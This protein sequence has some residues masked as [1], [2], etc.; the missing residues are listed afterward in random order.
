MV[1]ASLLC[2]L[3]VQ[4]LWCTCRSFIYLPLSPPFYKPLCT[5]TVTNFYSFFFN[6]FFSSL[7]QEEVDEEEEER[8]GHIQNTTFICGWNSCK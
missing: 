7:V 8:E 2:A 5:L 3:H 6:A 4:V 1:A